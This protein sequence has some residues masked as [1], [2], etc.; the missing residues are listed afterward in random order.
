MVPTRGRIWLGVVG[1]KQGR[2]G[3]KTRIMEE[4]I[5]QEEDSSFWAEIQQAFAATPESN[6]LR[7]E[8]ELWDCTVSDGFATTA[9][10]ACEIEE[11]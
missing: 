11:Q 4:A 3:T 8:C 9:P 7:T 10:R 1:P 5:G 2:T 6:E